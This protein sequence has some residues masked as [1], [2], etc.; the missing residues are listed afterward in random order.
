[1]HR[2][3][4]SR[5]AWIDLDRLEAWLVDNGAPYASDL[6]DTLDDAIESLRDFPTRGRHSGFGELRELIVPFRTWSYVI[7][8]SVT[9]SSVIIARIHHGLEDR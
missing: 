4:L 1:M 8:Y 6:G 3:E 7:T 9:V 5:L 2:I